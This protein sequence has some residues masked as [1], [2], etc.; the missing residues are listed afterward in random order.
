ME[1]LR[2]KTLLIV[3]DEPDLREPLVAEF[4]SFGCKVLQASNGRKA[5]EIIQNESIDAVISDIR[6]PGGDGVELLKNIKSLHHAVPVVMLITGFSDL[7]QE[8]AY[9]LGAEAILSKPFDLDE[10]DETVSRILT[11]RAEL[12]SRTLQ[13]D[14][15]KA[16]IER[17]YQDVSDAIA[18]GELG[19]GRGGLFISVEENQPHR[20]T[21]VSLRITFQNGEILNIDGYGIVR[22]VRHQAEMNMPV[23]VGIEFESLPEKTQAEIIQFTEQLKIRPFIPKNAYPTKIELL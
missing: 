19:L 23:G 12:W 22:W 2:G 9:H 3:E 15:I 20:G 5:F 6:M 18:Q 14:K 21:L 17:S 1:N 8:E 11:P 7:T 4:E 16:S 13:S 10:I